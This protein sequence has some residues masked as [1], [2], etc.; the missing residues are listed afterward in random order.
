[1]SKFKVG[2]RVRCLVTKEEAEAER[3]L[4]LS[5]ASVFGTPEEAEMIRN[6]NP[7]VSGDCGTVIYYGWYG[8][9][10]E[11][12]REIGPVGTSDRSGT[13]TW[14]LTEDQIE[15]VEEAKEAA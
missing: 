2:Q 5:R 3:E 7:P 1:M 14:W 13:N 9:E 11:F 6:M 10:V 12:D 4:Q 8:F 15:P